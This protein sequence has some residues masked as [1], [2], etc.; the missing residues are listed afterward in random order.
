MVQKQTGMAIRWAGGYGRKIFCAG[1]NKTGTASLLFAM[2]A[3]GFKPGYQPDAERL[4]GHWLRRT[5][6]HW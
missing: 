1:H 3:L 6:P 4:P 5:S 2:E